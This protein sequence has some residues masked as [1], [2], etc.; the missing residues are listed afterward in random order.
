MSARKPAEP[1]RG[2]PQASEVGR[3][4]LVTGGAGF[5]GSHLVE[6]LVAE[7][8][9]V[10]VLDDFSSGR[11]ANLTA[12]AEAIELVRGD[13]RDEDVAARAVAG[14][15]VVF[16]QAAVPSVPRSLAR[17]VHTNAVNV[18]GTLCVLAASRQAGV[19]RLVYAGSAAVHGDLPAGA[20]VESTPAAPRSPYALQ[21]HT[22]ELYCRLYAE[23]FGLE[24]ISLRYFN[25]YGPRQDPHGDYAAVIPRFVADCLAGVSPRVHGDGEQ[26]RDFVYV[27]DVARANRLAADAAIPAGAVCNVGSGRATRVL[28]LLAEIERQTGRGRAPVHEPPRAGDGGRGHA[29]LAYAGELLGYTPGVSLEEGLRLT[30]AYFEKEV[31]NP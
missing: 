2:E 29:S 27:A 7:G 13:V 5:I 3:K 21:K 17:P 4:A 25:V 16:H 23:L 20:V 15:E 10:R 12:V 18:E 8:W 31:V 26:T 11:P 6:S 28:D 14:V 22:G 9:R 1:A 24:T 19:R 30:I